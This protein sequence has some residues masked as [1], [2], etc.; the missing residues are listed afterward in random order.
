M[1]NPNTMKK[2]SEVELAELEMWAQRSPMIRVPEL[3]LKCVQMARAS[4]KFAKF[5]ARLKARYNA[6]Q[7]C[8]FCD[9]RVGFVC[10]ECYVLET[11]ID[12]YHDAIKGTT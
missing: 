1:T 6:A 4:L 5:M 3:I 11:L 7:T 10:P 9:L 12:E 8:S 2:I